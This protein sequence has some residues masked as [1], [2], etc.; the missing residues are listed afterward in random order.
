MF[1]CLLNS[2]NPDD[3]VMPSIVVHKLAWYPDYSPWCAQGC[4]TPCPTSL[5]PSLS[6][7]FQAPPTLTKAPNMTLHSST[8]S[9]TTRHQPLPQPT[10][11]IHTHT[12]THTHTAPHCT[13]LH[14]TAPHCIT[15]QE[16]Q[17]E[18]GS[19]HYCYTCNYQTMYDDRNTMLLLCKHR[20]TTVT[21][22]WPY[23]M[24]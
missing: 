13:T 17:W 19:Q 24:V 8:H 11:K 3:L 23:I 16:G 5:S 20:V 21:G 18:Q 1:S 14:H 10:P 22:V 9:S 2:K 6:D 15:H 12:H 7:L 4:S